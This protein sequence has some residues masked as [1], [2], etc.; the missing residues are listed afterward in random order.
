M[1]LEDKC[2]SMEA[3]NSDFVIKDKQLEIILEKWTVSPVDSQP[4][5]FIILFIYRTMFIILFTYRTIQPLQTR[6]TTTEDTTI[7]LKTVET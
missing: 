1:Q 5:L 2:N 4:K 6:N 3:K 7:I